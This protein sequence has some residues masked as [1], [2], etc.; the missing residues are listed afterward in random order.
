MADLLVFQNPVFRAFAISA[1]A[2]VLKVLAMGPLTAR[3]RFRTNT[4]ANPE[5]T[6]RTKGAVAVNNDVE[7]VRRAHLNDLENIPIFLAIAFVYVLTDPSPV[8]ASS[9][10]YT[11][12]GARIIHTISYLNEL[13]PWRALAY[14]A[15]VVSTVVIAIQILLKAFEKS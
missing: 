4:F 8:M 14:F 12:V 3:H 11:F 5:D 9:L 1:S 6:K 10:F 15:G 7:R 13:Q 2:L